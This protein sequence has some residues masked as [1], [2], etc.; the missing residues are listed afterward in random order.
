[1]KK[2]IRGL[3]KNKLPFALAVKV[4]IIIGVSYLLIQLSNK[5]KSI[6][7]TKYIPGM[8][9]ALDYAEHYITWKY[10]GDW[11]RMGYIFDSDGSYSLKPR[12]TLI[13]SCISS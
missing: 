8:Q 2:Q 9:N 10:G 13:N 1:M 5:E 7:E 12:E 3:I 6:E 4:I 11:Q